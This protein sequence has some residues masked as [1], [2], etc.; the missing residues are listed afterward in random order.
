MLVLVVVELYTVDISISNDT[1]SDCSPFDRVYPNH[2]DLE[3]SDAITPAPVRSSDSIQGVKLD[4]DA[5]QVFEMREGAVN[6]R[7]VD[8]SCF[9]RFLTSAYTGWL[10]KC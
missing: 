6:F 9:T 1:Q 4:N 2:S 5:F 7:T 10:I 8:V 3:K